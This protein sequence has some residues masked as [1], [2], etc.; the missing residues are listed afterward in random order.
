MVGT[1]IYDSNCNE[2]VMRGVNYPYSWYK[3][4][5]STRFSDMAGR[6]V[7]T[8]R[9][10]LSTGDQW[11]K[12]DT[13]E[14]TSI[15]SWLKSNQMVG[16][17]EVH[18]YT[19]YGDKSGVLDPTNRAVSYWTSIQSAL[20]GNEAYVM[21]NIA[22]EPFGNVSAETDRTRWETFHSGAIQALRNAGFKHTLIVDGPNWAQDWRNIMRDNTQNAVSTVFDSD[23][24][25]NTVFAVHMYDVFDSSSV[26]QTYFNNFLQHGHPLIIGEFAADHG[27]GN[28]VDEGTIMSQCESRGLG[29]LGWSWSGNSGDLAS[30]DITNNFNA[31]SLTSWGST[32]ITGSN[33]IEATAETC[34]CF[35]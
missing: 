32:L 9:V 29:Y 2:F 8:V 19:G 33:G 17:L 23:T 21:I 14:V 25:R 4:E 10:V 30:L 11:E 31:Q 15:I 5:G 16:V 28:N 24:E 13:N 3:Q 18:D 12:I 1:K 20:S 35:D 27:A 6:G 26:V 22:N 7:N 34:S